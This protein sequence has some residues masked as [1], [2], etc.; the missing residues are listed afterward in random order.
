[1]SQE[2]RPSALPPQWPPQPADPAMAQRPRMGTGVVRSFASLRTIAALILREM[3]TRYGRSPGGYVWAVLEPMGMII[4]L[5]IAFSLLVRTPP[6]GSSFILFF[7]TGFLPLN[8]YQTLSGTIARSI[9]FSRALL[10]YPAV[11]WVDAI[12]ARF[13]LNALTGI[14]VTYL[15]LLLI[16]TITEA[17]SVLAL[18]PIVNAL[19]LTLALGFG[20]GVLNCALTGLFPTWEL[21]W[22]IA[23]RPLFLA[24]GIFFIYEDLPRM[25]QD[26]LWYN[27]L[28]HITGIMRQGFYPMYEP[29]Y[30]SFTFVL[31]CALAPACMGLILLGRYHRDI[32][33]RN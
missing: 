13:L 24:S 31:V 23:T 25:V 2:T 26:I 16:L 10:M 8:L 32:L 5:A 22:S 28:M 27:P 11:S 3:S 15:L 33:E 18:L 14:M 1:M 20:I 12:V 6:L 7:A 4:L 9:S 19:A 21:V 17:R 30:I 29:N